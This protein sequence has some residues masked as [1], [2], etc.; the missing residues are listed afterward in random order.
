MA[1][2]INPRNNINLDIQIQTGT[3]ES[4]P[5]LHETH[6]TVRETEHWHRLPREVVESQSFKV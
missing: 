3:Q 1:S 2:R 6:F 4:P 5:D